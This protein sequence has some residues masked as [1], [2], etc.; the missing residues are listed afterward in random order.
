MF[1]LELVSTVLALQ[2]AACSWK[3]HLIVFCVFV[4]CKCR[5]SDN[6]SASCDVITFRTYLRS[7]R[8]SKETRPGQLT[9]VCIF[10]VSA[11]LL[12][13]NIY[14]FAWTL[15]TN[16]TRTFQSRQMLPAHSSDSSLHRDVPDTEYR[17]VS[18]TARL[19]N[20]SQ[21][22]HSENISLS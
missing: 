14:C 1:V 22:R 4:S 21:S 9:S 17:H 3:K 6:A 5:L 7:S 12:G 11:K 10:Q 15:E 16:M 18:V 13:T 20:T 8:G 19:T 2:A